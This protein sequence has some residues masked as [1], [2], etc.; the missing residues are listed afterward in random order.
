VFLLSAS[1]ANCIEKLQRDFSWGGIGEEFKYHLAS[2]PKDFSRIS[3]GGSGAE[4]LH[5]FNRALLGKWLW[6]YMH[7]REDLRRVIVDSKYGSS[8]GGWCSN[9]VHGSYGLESLLVMLDLRWETASQ[10]GFDIIRGVGIR[11]SR[12]LFQICIV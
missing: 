3:E 1:V 10:L 2:W 9:E 11:R 5:L 12:K 8:W 7:E 6:R 4:N